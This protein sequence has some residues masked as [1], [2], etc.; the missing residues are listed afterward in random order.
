M[1]KVYKALYILQKCPPKF[2]SFPGPQNVTSL[3]Y[4]VFA[5]MINYVKMKS[6]LST[7]GSKSNMMGV[8]IRK[9]KDTERWL[10]DDRG[11]GRRQPCDNVDTGERR[12]SED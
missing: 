4:R 8:L 11:T 7:V 12:P 2:M 5:D 3:G 10:S 9:G 6:Y 1:T